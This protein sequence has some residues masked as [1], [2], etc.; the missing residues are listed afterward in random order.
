MDFPSTTVVE[1]LAFLLPGF[2]AAAVYYALTPAPRPIPFERVVQALIFMVIVQSL[3]FGVREVAQLS[4]R[5]VTVGTWSADVQL[6]WSVLIAIPLGMLLAWISNRDRLHALLR[7]LRITDQTS[8]SSEW[9]GALCRNQGYVV[10]HLAGSRR[11]YGWPEEWPSTP[12]DGHF[13][14][15]RAEWLDDGDRVPLEGVDRILIRATDVEM[16]E[17]LKVVQ[18]P[19]DG[20]A[21]G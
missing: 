16:V 7:K 11:L 14:M 18:E 5:L 19:I 17:L 4:S 1:V 15:A 21:D 8:F 20:V 12:L 10:L 13:V 9:Y 3:V 6:V 2:L